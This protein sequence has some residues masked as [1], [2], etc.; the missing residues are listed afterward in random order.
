[1]THDSR[2][3]T[4]TFAGGCFWCVE[5]VFQPLRGVQKVVSGYIGGHVPRPSYEAVCSGAT[6][7]AEAVQITFDPAV[8]SYRTLL[9]LFFAFHDPTTRNRQGPDIGTQYRSAIYTH[10]ADPGGGGSHVVKELTDA[11]VFGAPIVTEIVPA[12]EFFPAEAYHQEYYERNSR[13]P[14]CRRWWH[15]RWRS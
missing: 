1:M 12:P 5:A 14:Y 13:Q 3:A 11:G 15:R 6:G 4:A 8:I 2:L 10:D 9:E 7:H